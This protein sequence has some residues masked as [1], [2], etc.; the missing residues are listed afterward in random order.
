MAAAYL[1]DE[2]I[3]FL[4]GAQHLDGGGAA[5]GGDEQET[6][7]DDDTRNSH[8]SNMASDAGLLA[9]DFRFLFYVR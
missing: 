8:L 1:G 6:R 3:E 7:D 2:V 4:L 9:V 5:D